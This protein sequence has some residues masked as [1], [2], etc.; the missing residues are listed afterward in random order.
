MDRGRAGGP[1]HPVHQGQRPGQEPVIILH[2]MG[3]EQPAWAP[4]LRLCAVR[5]TF[6]S[7]SD[8]LEC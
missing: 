5:V 3:A 7:D 2:L 4:P 6:P 8:A 1:G